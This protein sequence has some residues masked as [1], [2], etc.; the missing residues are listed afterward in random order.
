MALPQRRRNPLINTSSRFGGQMPS[1]G[2]DVADLVRRRLPR[3]RSGP[4]QAQP[5]PKVQ[6]IGD[7]LGCGAVGDAQ[8]TSQLRRSKIPN[9]GCPVRLAGLAVR[10]RVSDSV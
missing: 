6:R 9:G 3:L 5:M 4:D 8:H 1:C 2:G 7:Q 10:F